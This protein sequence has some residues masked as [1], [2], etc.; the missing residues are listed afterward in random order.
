MS[1]N[2]EYDHYER[3]VQIVADSLRNFLVAINTAGIGVILAVA[4]NLIEERINPEWALWPI[5][6]F[7]S[8]LVII[9][10]SMWL[11][12][13]REAKRSDAFKKKAQEPE[14]GFFCKSLT[15]DFIALLCFLAGSIVALVKLSS[16]T[17]LIGA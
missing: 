12:K 17:D 10:F 1:K 11:A 8:G 3:R 5:L 15:W 13:Y 14:F 9:A 16:V 7:V 2:N 4:G 6:L